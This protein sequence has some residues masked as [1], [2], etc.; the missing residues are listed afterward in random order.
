MITGLALPYK[1]VPAGSEGALVAELTAASTAKTPLVMMFWAPHW[2]FADVDVG[3]VD[4]PAY[5]PACDSDPAWG[6]NPNEINDC[7]VAAPDT[8]KVAWSG[9]QDRWP[10]AWAFLEAYS[11]DTAEQ[12]RMMKAIDQNGEELEAVVGAWIEA[13]PTV[14]QAWIDAAGQ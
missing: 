10:A 1:A 6:V 7:G 2:V 11:I 13:N 12:E 5:D 4:M 14:W 3:W 8:I 9:F